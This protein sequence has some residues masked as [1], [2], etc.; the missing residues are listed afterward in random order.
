MYIGRHPEINHWQDKG[1]V[2][3]YAQDIY[4]STGYKSGKVE[5][6]KSAVVGSGQTGSE[7]L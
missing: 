5:G 1:N 2:Y 3:M 6:G 7:G 4:C